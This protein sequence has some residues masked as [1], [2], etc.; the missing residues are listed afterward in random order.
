MTILPK[1]RSTHVYALKKNLC[2]VM[3]ASVAGLVVTGCN[4][5]NAEANKTQTQQTTTSTTQTATVSTPA[6][7]AKN[8]DE[9]KQ[10][11]TQNFAKSGIKTTVTSVTATDIPNMYW[12]KADGLPAVMSDSTGQYIFQGE[13]IKIG[14]DRP[15]SITGNLMATEAKSALAKIDKKDMIIFPAKGATKA[16]IYVFTDA[17]CGYC[18]KLHSQIDQINALGIEVRYLPW[19][20]SE[21]T[22]P[23]ME[24]IWCSKDRNTALTKAKNGEPIDAPQCDNPVQ[25]IHQIGVDL[26]VNGTPAIFSE[27]G[28]QLG[29]YLPPEALAKALKIQ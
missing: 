27:E 2:A 28:K 24:K 22:F 5:G 21:D 13:A 12:V 8:N 9:L 18:R 15:E 1:T 11:L 7:P 25:K 4:N 23:I 6:T 20:R 26:G 16:A 19:P 10:I 29:G 17:D 3:V 14:G